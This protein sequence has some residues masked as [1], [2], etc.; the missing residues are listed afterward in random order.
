M[1]LRT[2]AKCLEVCGVNTYV[3]LRGVLKNLCVLQIFVSAHHVCHVVPCNGCLRASYLSS[4][5]NFTHFSVCSF[6]IGFIFIYFFKMFSFYALCLWI[7]FSMQCTRESVGA[8]LL[9]SIHCGVKVPF[10]CMYMYEW[11]T[12]WSESTVNVCKP[13]IDK[14]SSLKLFKDPFETG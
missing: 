2:P 9:M 14:S 13:L 12:L 4:S 10:V 6:I 7:F 11:S 3:L 1:T 8:D 5:D